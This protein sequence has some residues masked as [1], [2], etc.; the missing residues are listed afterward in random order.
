L[1][2]R[3]NSDFFDALVAMKFLAREGDGANA[4]YS[5]LLLPPFIWIKPALAMWAAFWSCSTN[6]SS[7]SGTTCP[8][9]CAPVSPK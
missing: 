1:H 4:K 3:A 9:L 6:A 7:S 5:T 2:P 8:R